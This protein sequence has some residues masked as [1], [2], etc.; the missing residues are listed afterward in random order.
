MSKS[1]PNSR[2]ELDINLP[3]VILFSSLLTVFIYILLIPIQD[4]YIGILF[5]E[6]GITQYLVVFLA[7]F[8]IT[9]SID[10]YIKIR[11]EFNLLRD[12][13]IPENVSFDNPKSVQVREMSNFFGNFKNVVGNRISRIVSAYIHSGSR[14]ASSELAIDDSSFYLSASESSYNFPRILVWAIP[15]LGFIGTVLGISRAVNGF[16]SFLEG[17]AEVEQIK[18]GI[19]TVTSGLAVA[20]DT[21]LLALLLSVLVMIPLVLVERREGQLL[22]AI[23]IFINDQ[24]LPRLKERQ[25]DAILNT[26]T[27]TDT[28]NKAIKINLPTKEE[29]IQPIKEA[30]PT[31]EELIKPAEIFAREAA[32]N[33][34]TEFLTQF[35]EIQAQ[36]GKL[37]EGIKQL[38]ET[39]L[40]DRE[41]FIQSYHEQQ[42]FNL[43]LINDLK[44]FVE[45]I[46][47]QNQTNNQGIEKQV[48]A[49]AF[50]LQSVANVLEDKVNSLEKS[51]AK[52]AEITKL[53]GSLNKIVSALDSA[54]KMED[55][56]L[57]IK[58]QITLLQPVMKDLSKPRIVR[59]VEQI[60]E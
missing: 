26:Q 8:V 1:I 46:K 28:I 18:E 36:E 23:D 42:N 29:F 30:L 39:I 59:L 47:E 24:L 33:L 6:R 3:F 57:M 34:L 14:K 13:Q 51:T 60:E 31:T 52:I 20:F 10:K 40:N 15:L 25:G 21:T 16:S 43:N 58:E 19:G 50:Q 5:I 41:R 38:N 22:L 56:L 17:S 32:Q 49:I 12:L 11:K 9:S 44:S 55:T 48:G 27:V 54:H 4:T 37:V 35:N 7:S 45:L 53:E 2:Q